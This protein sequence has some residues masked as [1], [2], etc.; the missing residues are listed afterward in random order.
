[1]ARRVDYPLA[2][3]P[4][5]PFSLPFLRLPSP[6]MLPAALLAPLLTRAQ[7]V[8]CSFGPRPRAPGP[9]HRDVLLLATVK[10]AALAATT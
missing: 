4:W 10:G 5:L 2:H 7:A 1:M 3:L 6:P 8:N 9:R